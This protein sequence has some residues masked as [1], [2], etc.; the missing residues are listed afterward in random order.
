MAKVGVVGAGGRMGQTVCRAVLGA[1]GLE[2]VAAVDPEHA[3][4]PVTGT[5]LEDRATVAAL[6]DAGAEVVV[7][8]T[9]L[10]AARQNVPQ[11]AEHGIHAVVGTT[12]F[13]PAD[14][15]EYGRLFAASAANAVI[16]PNFTIGAVLMMRFAEMAAPWFESAEIIE[17]HHDRKI[18]APSGTAV[19]TAQRMAAASSSWTPDPT[20]TETVPGTARRQ[21][22]RHPRAHGAAPRR[23]PA[24]GSG[25]RYGRADPHDPPRQLRSRRL[26]ARRAARRCAKCRSGRASR[27]GSIRCSACEREGELLAV[28]H[29]VEA[30]LG[31]QPEQVAAL[32]LIRL[33]VAV[34]HDRGPAGE[35][36]D[37]E[38]TCR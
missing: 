32:H 12:G 26:H 21:R 15:E 18:D 3:G 37:G 6:V 24:S 19:R 1:D 17:L 29:H 25:A 9:V 33:V 2:L 23:V 38:F 7:D 14:L 5:A 35:R 16:A 36:G 4:E 22:R 31:A 30:V 11:Y 8:F 34:Q 20:E 13:V 10:A 27:S 28:E